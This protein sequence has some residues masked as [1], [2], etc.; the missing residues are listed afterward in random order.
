[1]MSTDATILVIDED[2]ANISALE[3]LLKSPHRSFLSAGNAQDGLKKAVDNEVDLIILDIQDPVLN[4]LE[5]V[6]KLKS[7]TRTTNIPIIFMANEEMKCQLQIS[8]MKDSSVDYFLKPFVPYLVQNKVSLFLKIQSQQKELMNKKLSLQRAQAEICAL[9]ISLEKE[10]EQTK[11]I[12][13][14]LDS[15]FYSVSHDLR[16]PLRILTGYSAILEEDYSHVF[17]DEVKK[18][19]SVIQRKAVHLDAMIER[20]LQFSA[21]SAKELQKSNIDVHHL[22]EKIIHNMSDSIGNTKIVLRE[23]P[24]AT[25]DLSLFTHVWTNLLSNAFKYSSKKENPEIEVGSYKIENEIVYYIKDNGVGF[26]MQY[27]NKLFSV[28]QRLHQESEFD[29]IGVGLS[30]VQRIIL[31]H[32]GRIWAEGE[33]NTGATF[34]FT[35]PQ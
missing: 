10:R 15:L 20:L 31:K 27:S 2:S 30:I 23:L 8:H 33:V 26:D 4:G 19:V 32:G 12:N 5:V 24:T 9:T 21:L 6:Q 17:N 18:I 34:Y 35:L 28:F 7:N 29:G 13:S 16:A 25:A 11:R 14:E 3:K 1:M 22:V